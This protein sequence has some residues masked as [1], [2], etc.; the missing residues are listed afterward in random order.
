MLH[1]NKSN[2]SEKATGCL[3]DVMSVCKFNDFLTT[4]AI[5]KNTNKF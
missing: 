5:V 3:K 4:K 2:E 1:Q